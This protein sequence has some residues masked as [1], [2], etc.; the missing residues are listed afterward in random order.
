VLAVIPGAVAYSARTGR[1]RDS[2]QEPGSGPDIVIW[3]VGRSRQP[4][5]EWPPE[6]WRPTKII[7]LNYAEDSP[8]LEYAW[9]LGVDY[10]SGVEMFRAQAAQ[11]REFWRNHGR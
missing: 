5:C 10:R 7:D 1:P 6:Q 4:L 8:G 2:A 3:A 11:Q 9:R